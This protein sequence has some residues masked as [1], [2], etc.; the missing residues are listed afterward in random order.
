MPLLLASNK[1]KL[2]FIEKFIIELPFIS[3]PQMV[4]PQT[5]NIQDWINM[6][7]RGLF[8]YDYDIDKP[9]PYRNYKLIVFPDNPLNFKDLPIEV[10]TILFPLELDLCFENT[11]EFV[12]SNF[13][14]IQW[15][16]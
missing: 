3:K 10:Q 8:S 16:Y 13:I 11:F 9:F 12:F 2:E 1:S 4:L 6:A 7:K 14:D 5:G 15:Y